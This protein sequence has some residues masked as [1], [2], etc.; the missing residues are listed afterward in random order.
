[1]QDS[2]W[3]GVDWRAHHRWVNVRG[4]PINLVELGEGPPI[5]FIHG[6]G[7]SWKNWLEQLPVFATRHRV[8]ALDLPG[9][10]H[11]PMPTERITMPGYVIAVEELLDQLGFA[12][13][14]VVG[15]SMGG[16]IA[17]ELAL[18]APARVSRLGLISPA[19]VPIKRRQERVW[20]A[21]AAFPVVALV[22]A[23]L[24]SHA[25]ELA[26]RPGARKWLLRTVAHRSDR[27]PPA[28]AAE[29][30]RGMGKPGLWPAFEDLVAHSVS[31]RLSAISC[32]TLIVWGE[33]DH[34]LPVHHA[35]LFAQAIPGARKVL[36]PDTAHVAMFERPLEVN[37][38]LAELF[39]DDVRD[40]ERAAGEQPAEAEQPAAAT[41]PAVGDRPVSV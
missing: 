33:H 21:R 10:G 19:G 16:L 30:L 8:V 20:A 1:M 12:Q 23:Y 9:F 32:P 13:A 27:I 36:Y 18:A 15:N 37:R 3:L 39:G 11:S 41:S 22:C 14:A 38:L 25:D 24:G 35:E 17:A 34:V 28:L 6:L 4:G 7:G 40:L 26:C 31:E 29:Q 5:V 2:P